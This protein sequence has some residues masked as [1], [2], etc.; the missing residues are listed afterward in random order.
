MKRVKWYA[1]LAQHGRAIMQEVRTAEC[2]ISA[3]LNE[4]L[5]QTFTLQR[6]TLQSQL[7]SSGN[8][9]SRIFPQL[10]SGG[11][12]FW[13]LTPCKNA[14][15]AADKKENALNIDKLIIERPTNFLYIRP[16]LLEMEESTNLS[17]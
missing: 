5:N 16:N 11:N 13:M 9:A 4:I 3:L 15:Y 6:A 10:R 2:F 8:L 7:R 17:N 1:A 12:A 14:S